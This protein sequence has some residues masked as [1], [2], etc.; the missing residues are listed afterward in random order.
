V[1]TDVKKVCQ[2]E[3]AL[4]APSFNTR[5]TNRNERSAKSDECA[6]AYTRKEKEEGEAEEGGIKNM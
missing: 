1:E 3:T 4:L 2:P 5:R 6:R